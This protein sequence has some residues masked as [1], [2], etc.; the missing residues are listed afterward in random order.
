M[1]GGVHGYL[2]MKICAFGIKL[3]GE[4]WRW[5]SRVNVQGCSFDASSPPHT[6]NT[7]TLPTPSVHAA[8][9]DVF[10]MTSPE[11]VYFIP[12]VRAEFTQVWGSGSGHG[13]HGCVRGTGGEDQALLPVRRAVFVAHCR[14]FARP[15][16]GAGYGMHSAHPLLHPP[17]L[18]LP[19]SFRPRLLPSSA[20][21]PP[22]LRHSPAPH[23]ALP[24][25][26]PSP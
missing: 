6:S 8:F 16:Q 7:L 17:C 23:L 12:A 2:C 3:D 20:T 1:W 22:L 18:H 9:M 15:L 13:T 26:S 14:H 19:R 11:T 10:V 21:P 5:R 4:I 25:S 24:N